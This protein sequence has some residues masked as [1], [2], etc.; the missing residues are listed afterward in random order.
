MTEVLPKSLDRVIR[1]LSQLPGIGPKSAQR[2]TYYLLRKPETLA[3][4]LS[5][6]LSHLHADTVLCQICFNFSEGQPCA[7]C[8]SESRDRTQICVVEEPHHVPVI[9]RIGEYRG[10]YHVLHGAIS[11]MDG[12]GPDDIRLRELVH[13]VNCAQDP[14][15]QEVIVA[16]SPSLSG[17]ATAEWIARTLKPGNIAVTLLAR[18]LSSGS[19]IEFADDMTFRYAMEGRRPLE[20]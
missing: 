13:R 9:E 3:L 19:D 14:G 2:L 20:G 11:P 7:I 17:Q 15:V 8:Q 6:A 5:E 4:A 16:A 18:G 10:L 12:V 1:A